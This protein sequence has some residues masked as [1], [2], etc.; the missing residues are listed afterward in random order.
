MAD[1]I[2]CATKDTPYW[3]FRAAGEAPE[4]DPDGTIPKGGKVSFPINPDPTANYMSARLDGVGRV[5]VQP[6]DFA[7]C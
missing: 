5:L 1:V 2:Y 6:G 4:G 3:K 7:P